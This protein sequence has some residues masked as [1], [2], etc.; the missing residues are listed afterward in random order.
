MAN[1]TGTRALGLP[2]IRELENEQYHKDVNVNI[3]SKDSH[4]KEEKAAFLIVGPHGQQG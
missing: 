3:S 4:I 2:I 1:R